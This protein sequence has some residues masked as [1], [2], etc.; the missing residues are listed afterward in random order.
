MIG[1]CREMYGTLDTTVEVV[2]FTLANVII[3]IVASVLNTSIIFLM[4]TRSVLRQPSFFLLGA[5]AC[6]DLIMACVGGSLYLTITLKGISKDGKIETATCFITSSFMVNNILLLCCI[7]YDRHQCIKCSMDSRPYTTRRQVAVKIVLCLVAS[8]I[9]SCLFYV[10]TVYYLRIRTIEL[11]FVLTMGC[12]CYIAIYYFKLS[13]IVRGNQI[14]NLALRPQDSSDAAMRRAPPR[15]ANLNK[16]ILLLVAAYTVAFVSAS[17]TAIIRNSKYRFK[18][19]PS[20]AATLATLWSMTFMFSNAVIDPL[21]Y[22]YR[23]DAIGKE[24]RKVI[25]FYQRSI[26]FAFT[27]LKN[28]NKLICILPPSGPLRYFTILYHFLFD[29]YFPTT[30]YFVF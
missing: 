13:R 26:S 30:F 15:N 2:F 3:I 6:T 27:S 23:S 10:E 1:S 22:T 7:T 9:L 18:V 25:S 4:K 11:I 19:S 5:L 16:S 12:F 21:I 8:F 24:L 14:H 17:V 28:F 29:F 20:K